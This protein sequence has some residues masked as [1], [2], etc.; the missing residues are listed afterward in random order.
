MKPTVARDALPARCSSS[1]AVVAS[2]RTP[3]TC[4]RSGATGP[5]TCAAARSTAVISCPRKRRT[6]L[7]R[8]CTA[9]SP[10]QPGLLEGRVHRGTLHLLPGRLSSLHARRDSGSGA[11]RIEVEGMAAIGERERRTQWRENPMHIQREF[12][13][14]E[15]G[16]M[17]D[18]V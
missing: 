7:T 14:D 18:L 8:S 3:T 10:G 4:W 9:S 1:G 15:V 2:W 11:T 6:R 16:P 13:H 12:F 5:T 17:A